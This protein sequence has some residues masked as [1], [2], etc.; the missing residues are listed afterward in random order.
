[1][2]MPLSLC[3]DGR[4]CLEACSTWRSQGSCH[5]APPTASCQTSDPSPT[6][7]LC[8]FEL[9][10]S[11]AGVATVLDGSLMNPVSTHVSI[12]VAIAL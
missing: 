7:V 2:G 8:A 11:E 10:L 4:S 5:L 1:M 12:H 9:L 3:E 6:P